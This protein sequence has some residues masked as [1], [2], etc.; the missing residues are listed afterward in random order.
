[1]FIQDLHTPGRKRVW[2]SWNSIPTEMFLDEE[3][4]DLKLA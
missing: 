3:Q 1:M 4:R 2:S